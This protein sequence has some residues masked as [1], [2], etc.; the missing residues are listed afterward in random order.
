M[1][2]ARSGASADSAGVGGPGRG[3]AVDHRRECDRTAR[4][5]SGMGS[6]YASCPAGIRS[7]EYVRAGHGRATGG[8]GWSAADASTV[9]S[10]SPGGGWLR[11]LVEVI[12]APA[13]GAV[14]AILL[15]TICGTG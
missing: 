6:S 15:R 12:D 5:G 3:G 14:A 4:G 11:I 10:L 1:S 9:A 8:R 13:A 2:R 7:G